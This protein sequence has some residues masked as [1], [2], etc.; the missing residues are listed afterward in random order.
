VT[1][2]PASRLP[3]IRERRRKTF[4]DGWVAA[5]REELDTHTGS[6]D[7]KIPTPDEVVEAQSVRLRNSQEFQDLLGAVIQALNETNSNPIKVE[8]DSSKFESRVVGLVRE[9]FRKAGWAAFSQT[10]KNLII[11]APVPDTNGR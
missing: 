2:S 6:F 11:S 8:V 4:L 9:D 10:E 3:R 1:T 7:M 5:V